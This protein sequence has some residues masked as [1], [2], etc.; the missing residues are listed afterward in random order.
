MDYR[1]ICMRTIIIKCIPFLTCQDNELVTVKQRIELC[2]VEAKYW[3]IMN[4][5]KLKTD[6]T[7]LLVLH[8]K[9]RSQAGFCA[10]FVCFG[11][12]INCTAVQLMK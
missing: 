5:T 10:H 7:E 2:M 9:F 3:M 6:K 4:K 11:K 12:I 8:S 1:S